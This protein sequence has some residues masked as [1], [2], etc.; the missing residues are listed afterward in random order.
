MSEKDVARAFMRRKKTLAI[1]ESCTGGLIAD[2][3]TDLPGSSR[4]FVLG[5]IAYANDAKQR[6]LG[7]RS[8]TI[9]D[10][11]AVSKETALEMACGVRRLGRSHVGIGVTG[12][13]GPGGGTRLK[14]V[15][16]VF[17][18]VCAGSRVYFK[19]FRFRGGRLTVKKQAKTAALRLL[20][21]C[22]SL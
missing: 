16:T 2:A 19:K 7:V 11:G 13:A 21:E 4:F 22:L 8:S 5:V 20:K 17:I 14:P 12:I 10:H 15:G 1:A 9:K 6:V 18:S 3:L